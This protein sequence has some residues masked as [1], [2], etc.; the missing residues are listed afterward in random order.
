MSIFYLASSII[1][2]TA[3]EETAQEVPVTV[4]VPILVCCYL[5][6]WEIRSEGGPRITEIFVAGHSSVTQLFQEKRQNIN[7]TKEMYGHTVLLTI[8]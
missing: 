4:G 5:L 6:S 3:G 8:Q 1:R 7:N 2:E